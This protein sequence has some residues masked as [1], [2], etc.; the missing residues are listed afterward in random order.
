MMKKSRLFFLSAIFMILVMM[1]AACSRSASTGIPTTSPDEDQLNNILTSV[2][3]QAPGGGEQTATLQPPQD[4]PV[5]TTAV[6]PTNTPKPT[7][8]PIPTP[9]LVVPDKYKLQKGEFPYCIARRFN[10][11]ITTL[12]NT[13]NLSLTQKFAEGLVLTIPQN[14]PAFKGDPALANHPADYTVKSGDTFYRIACVYGDVWPE[15]IAVA[16]Q[17]QLTDKLTAGTVLHIP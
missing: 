7:N 12:L 2:A 9:V 1:L 17:M 15:E 8:T 4:T 13:N 16:N 10:I 14:A 11:D 5:A 6:P 3:S